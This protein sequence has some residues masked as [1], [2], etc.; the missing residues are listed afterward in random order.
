MYFFGRQVKET[1]MTATLRNGDVLSVITY[2]DD[3]CGLSRND[4]PM[5]VFSWP[6]TQLDDCVV[7]F[8]RLINSEGLQPTE[9]RQPGQPTPARAAH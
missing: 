9:S 6:A 2:R 1:L 8:L 7:T 3:R 4:Q 5:Y